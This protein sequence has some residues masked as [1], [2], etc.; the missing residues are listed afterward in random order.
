M[1]V[2]TNAIVDLRMGKTKLGLINDNIG[3]VI[4]WLIRR[5]GRSRVITPTKDQQKMEQT[6][7]KKQGDN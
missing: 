4:L 2:S 7:L 6:I 3:L 1:I 5:A